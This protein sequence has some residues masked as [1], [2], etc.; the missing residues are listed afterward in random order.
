MVSFLSLLRQK[1][2]SF[3]VPPAVPLLMVLSTTQEMEVGGLFDQILLDSH[4]KT[5]PMAKNQLFSSTIKSDSFLCMVAT[6][7]LQEII[8]LFL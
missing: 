3:C 1:P 4:H 8:F 2:G 7:F 6:L 5:V